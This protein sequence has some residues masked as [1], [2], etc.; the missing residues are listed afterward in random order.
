MAFSQSFVD[1]ARNPGTQ[2]C[3]AALNQA[4]INLRF[5]AMDL[6]NNAAKPG[7]FPCRQVD[8]IEIARDPPCPT[9]HRQKRGIKFDAPFPSKAQFEKGLVEGLAMKLFGVNQGAI[10]V[11][12]QSLQD[13]HAASNALRT[14]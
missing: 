14:S 9:R 4:A 6:W 7:L 1:K 8:Q 10:N 12:E 3:G 5:H 13:R 11:K 2:P